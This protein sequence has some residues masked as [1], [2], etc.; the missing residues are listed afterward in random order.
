ME[1]IEHFIVPDSEKVVLPEEAVALDTDDPVLVLHPRCMVQNSPAEDALLIIS[2]SEEELPE[3]VNEKPAEV[4]GETV[5][6]N[7]FKR[8]RDIDMHPIRRS[9]RLEEF[10]KI[11]LPKW[12]TMM[13]DVDTDQGSF[14]YTLSSFMV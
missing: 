4:V 6:P 14:F 7:R 8:R 2:D 10:L 5:D 3:D 11:I 13:W 1:N 12:E 9:P